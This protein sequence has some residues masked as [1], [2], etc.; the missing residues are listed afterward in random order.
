MQNCPRCAAAYPA[1]VGAFCSS[2][3]APTT[4]SPA[5]P[6]AAPA[7]MY[8]APPAPPYG[9][10]FG[11][12]GPS[13]VIAPNNYLLWA[14]LSTLLC[15]LPLGIV[16]IVFATKVDSLAARGDLGGAL[17]ASR[18]AKNFA[19]AAAC[20]GGAIAAVYVVFILVAV[21]GASAGLQ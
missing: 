14:I 13:P 3:G 9:Q 20:V 2:C 8:A 11:G 7:P 4:A 21:A 1:N 10:P 6:F 15:C 12:Y 16:S 17:E 18:K 5:A 19:I